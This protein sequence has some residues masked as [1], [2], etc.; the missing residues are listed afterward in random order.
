MKTI[1]SWFLI[2]SV[3]YFR[4]V[5]KTWVLTIVMVSLVNVGVLSLTGT[6]MTLTSQARSVIFEHATVLQS[7]VT[8]QEEMLDQ[9][10][11]PEQTT[12]NGMW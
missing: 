6:L 9:L 5:T 7:E 2:T 12:D 4:M 3:T 11:V 10:V 8:L 1:V